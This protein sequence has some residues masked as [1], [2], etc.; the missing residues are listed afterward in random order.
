MKDDATKR[1]AE[2]ADLVR[3]M[4]AGENLARIESS[5]TWFPPRPAI[6]KN[7][8]L[9]ARSLGVQPPLAHTLRAVSTL[10]DEN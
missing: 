8:A 9:V 4:R 5:A 7:P 3:R 10:T 6:A 1:A 2:N